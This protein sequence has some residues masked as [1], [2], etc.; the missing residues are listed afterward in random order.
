VSDV[1]VGT[2][3]FVLMQIRN[4]VA[5][6][7]TA[8]LHLL[9]CDKNI[10]AELIYCLQTMYRAFTIAAYFL[11][12]FICCLTLFE[13]VIYRY[14]TGLG[15]QNTQVSLSKWHFMFWL[16][17]QKFAWE[18]S[19]L[20]LA[21]VLISFLIS[22]CERRQSESLPT[23]TQPL[24]WLLISTLLIALIKEVCEFTS[25]KEATNDI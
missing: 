16:P 4:S 19:T 12:E 24:I 5:F 1:V 7:L 20:I 22:L 6:F 21:Q 13:T 15:S 9:P 14:Y 3:L 11:T 2:Y 18:F 10:Q 17:T 25:P 23:A 8:A